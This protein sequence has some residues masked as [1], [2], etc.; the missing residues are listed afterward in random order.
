L[1]DKGKISKDQADKKAEAEYD[2]FN[3]I[4]K[5]TSDFDKEVKKMLKSKGR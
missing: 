2:E 4:Q 1:R 3:K 5:I